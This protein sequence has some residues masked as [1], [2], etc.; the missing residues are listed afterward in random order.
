MANVYEKDP[1]LLSQKPVLTH[2]KTL[3][4]NASWSGY[5]GF[6]RQRVGGGYQVSVNTEST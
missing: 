4:L 1:H 3:V 5:L 6:W 2:I